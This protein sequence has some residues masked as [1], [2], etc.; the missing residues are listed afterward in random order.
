[1][2]GDY[3]W[4]ISSGYNRTNNWPDMSYLELVDAYHA[5]GAPNVT[6]VPLYDTPDDPDN[7]QVVTGPGELE[8]GK[9]GVGAHH[10]H[11]RGQRQTPS[12]HLPPHPA[13]AFSGKLIDLQ[14]GV[15]DRGAYTGERVR[16][17]FL[18]TLNNH[19]GFNSEDYAGP[20]SAVKCH[21]GIV[22]FA[23]GEGVNLHDIELRGQRPAGGRR[24]D[25]APHH[26]GHHPHFYMTCAE[27]TGYSGPDGLRGPRH[28]QHR[29]S[30]P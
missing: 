20:T 4:N 26:P 25:R 21:L 23:G 27:Y 19:S 14:N 1:M 13:L 30:Q 11:D 7:W 24:G 12:E 8:A 9:H 18:P 5:G 29:R 15:W 10:L 28:T 2:T 16:I 17:I 22:E 3:C 6:A